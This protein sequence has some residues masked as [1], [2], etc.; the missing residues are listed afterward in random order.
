MVTG[1]LAAAG[2]VALSRRSVGAPPYRR[3]M[4]RSRI[5]VVLIDLPQDVFER[6]GA[7]WRLA[8]GGESPVPPAPS[9]EDPYASLDP[10]PGG[11][12]FE[13]QRTGAGTPPSLHLDIETD[14]VPAEVERLVGLGATVHERREGWVILTDPAGLLFCVVP[15]QTGSEFDA[16]ATR[17]P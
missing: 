2:R 3:I 15:V 9:A 11:V 4:H 6:A 1:P 17:W 16:H 7:F 13:L 5:A 10:L 8:R 12:M 14:D